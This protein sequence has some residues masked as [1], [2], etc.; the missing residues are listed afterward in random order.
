MTYAEASKW[1][2][3][4]HVSRMAL[5]CGFAVALGG[6]VATGCGDQFKNCEDSRT[7][8][9][10]GGTGGSS[11]GGSAGTE[12]G[13]SGSNGEG[14]SPAG[15]AGA[16]S[17]VSGA[18]GESSTPPAPGVPCD[19]PGAR[20]CGAPADPS[21]L[22]CA[23]GSWEELSCDPGRVC[24]PSTGR[25][26]AVVEGCEELEPGGTFC[27]GTLLQTCSADLLSLA[28]EACEGAC[29]D[30]ECLPPVCG[31]GIVQQD[32]ECDDGN[33]VDTDECLPSC[34]L[35]TC[36][37][38]LIWDGK[39]TCDDGNDDN[40]DECP[41]TC[42]EAAC[43]DG[44]VQAD[45]EGCD[46]G[47]LI[48]GDGCS[49]T[50]A[51]ETVGVATMGRTTCAWL[52]DGR[53]KCWG[54][55]FYGQLGIAASLPFGDEASEVVAELPWLPVESV[56]KMSGNVRTTCALGDAEAWCWGN[57]NWAYLDRSVIPLNSPE[58]VKLALP[59]T[60]RTIAVGEGGAHACAIVDLEEAAGQVRCFGDNRSGELGL[61]RSE[62]NL[63]LPAAATRGPLISAPVT[64]VVAGAGFSCALTSAN[65][66]LCW[67]RGHLGQLGAP[68]VT[69]W[70]TLPS[71]RRPL[72]V[73]LGADFV[74]TQ[75]AAGQD[76]V[77]A[78]SSRGTVKCWGRGAEGQLG[79]EDAGARGDDA[80]E[81]GSALPTVALG[82]VATAVA[83]GGL[84]SCA[85]LTTGQVKCWGYDAFG[86]LAQPALIAA[87]SIG[88]AA[89][90]MGAT[91]PPVD[92]GPGVTVRSISVGGQNVCVQ[93]TTAEI[94]CWGDNAAGQLGVGD[95]DARG[96]QLSHMGAK[97]LS[98]ELE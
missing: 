12:P 77:C 36:G 45:L 52:S 18:A 6:G 91:L 37:D 53:S 90:E 32:E 43:G 54:D 30:G 29:E 10:T 48:N 40:T 9:N 75:L 61:G 69:S 85:L 98:V 20:L 71:E 87:G 60:P 33:E 2:R 58:P 79:Y 42:E 3:N 76:H 49:R 68:G 78:L 97:L 56:T 82:G 63:Q 17:G 55:N 15:D 25:C 5:M 81:M 65:S 86:V 13:A 70:G 35:A 72:V 26:A 66:V 67:G 28:E 34:V 7:C 38:S 46:D 74:P 88:D 8:A 39:E 22:L 16:D 44:F 92:L 50:C 89:G 41:T 31:D 80:A 23:E 93:L 11:Q 62:A 94:K 96:T 59:G 47:N 51:A 21:F 19:E 27:S 24:D 84:N 57:L 14:G 95:P 73:A 4:G 83:A 64:S 1:V